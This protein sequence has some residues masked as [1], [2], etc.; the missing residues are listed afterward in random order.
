MKAKMKATIPSLAERI[1][2]LKEEVEDELDR[3]AEEKRPPSIPGPWLRGN[4]LAKAGGNP[5]VAY[6]IAVAEFPQ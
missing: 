6:L 2:Q 3:L 1:Q 4:W 5:F